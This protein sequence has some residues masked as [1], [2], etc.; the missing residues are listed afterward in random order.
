MTRRVV[1]FILCSMVAAWL[2]VSFNRVT[3]ARDLQPNAIRQ[4]QAIMQEKARRTPAQRKLESHLHAAGQVARGVLSVREIP[5]LANV[6]KMLVFDHA[7]RVH[8]DIQ[9]T[10]SKGLLAEIAAQGGTVESSFV[11]YGAIRAWIPLLK[12]EVLARRNDV[13]FIRPADI[14]I[15]NGQIRDGPVSEQ[16]RLRAAQQREYLRKKLQ[17]VLPQIESKAT[18]APPRAGILNTAPVNTK[19]LVS[20]GADLVQAQGITGDGVK[21]GVLSDGVDSLSSMQVAGNLPNNVTVLSGQAGSGD[22]GTAMLEIVYD[23]APGADLYFATAVT[24]AAQFATNIQSLADAGCNVI[25]DD[26][27]YFAEGVFQDG[28]IAQAV[29]SVTASGVLYFSAAGNSGNVDSGTSGTWEGD[30]N[31]TGATIPPINTAEG[32]TVTVHAFDAT[33]NYDQVTAYSGIPT[34]L[35]WSDPLGASCNDYD[36]FNMDSTLT[37]IWDYSTGYQTCTQDPIE[38]IYAPF[39]NDVLVIVLFDGVARALHLDT[40]RARLAINTTGAT[41]A[42]N[43][44][45]SAVTV[46]ATPAQATIFTAGSQSPEFYS[47]D[48]PRKIF[49][50]PNGTPITPGNFLFGTGGGTTLDKVDLTTADCG[51]SAVPGFNPFCGTS[52]AAPTAAA[53]AAL[54]M[55]ANPD[56]D[57]SQV[58]DAMKSTAL[59]AHSGFNPRTVGAG[60]A[61]ANL[62]VDS[63]LV[64]NPIASFSP[65][66]VNLGNQPV[67]TNGP[68]SSVKLTNTG[69]GSLSISSY[70]I[71]GGNSADFHVSSGCG[72]SLSAGADCTF[73]VY[74]NPVGAGPRKSSLRVNDGAAD[75]PQSI[76]L[77]GVGTAL[78]HSPASL[79]F[80]NKTVG[81]TSSPLVITLANGGSAA[82]HLWQIAILGTNAGDFSKTA[83]TCGA[84]LGA[85]ANC[86]VTVT[87]KPT[88]TGARSAAVLVSND[89]GGSPQAVSLTGTG[90]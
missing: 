83:T 58:L 46:A 76:L 5:A 61:M 3:F 36:L 2:A 52:A 82:I 10:V 38:G 6:N 11:Q 78:S 79:D 17:A 1:L 21:V 34:I 66:F 19:G 89:G 26:V 14:A 13:T 25:V 71:A 4:I 48:G 72:G 68:T 9:G 59:T 63:V 50:Y 43:A 47:S 29:N 32:K 54:V 45:G 85:S 41:F 88:A 87:F 22:E 40:E 20:E 18:P 24:S 84:T 33:H 75:S 30:F 62:S 80:G 53:I 73:S 23:L 57:A 35:Q 74:F 90:I 86:T 31:G 27:T 37:Y 65:S 28:I 16:Y 70:S 12:A 77:T 56:L 15:L 49:Y 81:V 51:Q 7:R 39:T 42:H 44:A 67:G 8:V 55:S 64:P 60:I 69:T